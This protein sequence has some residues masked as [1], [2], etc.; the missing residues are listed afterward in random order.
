[1][2]FANDIVLIRDNL[3]KMKSDLEVLSKA[4]EE[5]AGKKQN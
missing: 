5:S 4:L 1:M 2:L 3:R